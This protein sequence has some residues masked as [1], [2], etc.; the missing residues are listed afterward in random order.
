MPS[1]TGTEVH[2]HGVGLELEREAHGLIAVPGRAGDLDAL[3]EVES[4]AEGLGERLVVV[5]DQ[6]A[7]RRHAVPHVVDTH[8][9][10]AG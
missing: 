10:P 8:E 7:K 2:H 3:V 1:S 6:N 5:G 9:R 4:Q